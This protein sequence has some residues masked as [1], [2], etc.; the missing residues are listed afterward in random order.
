MRI[1]KIIENKDS[2]EYK[3]R[4]FF[5][6]WGN[7][8]QHI[9]DFGRFRTTLDATCLTHI[10]RH[11]ETAKLRLYKFSSISAYEAVKLAKIAFGDEYEWE[12]TST[13]NSVMEIES[14]GNFR[15]YLYFDTTDFIACDELYEGEENIAAHGC[16]SET[17]CMS[18]KTIVRIV[19]FLR[20]NGY[21]I[22]YD[23]IPSLIEDG[24]FA[25]AL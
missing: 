7:Q 14:K 16:T 1:T 5:A 21:D 20:S 10:S 13:T 18:D 9:N 15:I 19:D 12:V 3:M 11:L 6:Y 4:V 2:L 23:D 24:R 22:G 8:Y 25:V 17:Y